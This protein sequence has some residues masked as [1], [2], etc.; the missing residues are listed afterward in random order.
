MRSEAGTDRGVQRRRS[1]APC[2]GLGKEEDTERKSIPKRE[3]LEVSPVQCSNEPFLT[4]NGI[5]KDAITGNFYRKTF[6]HSQTPKI[7]SFRFF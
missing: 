3:Q 4:Q 6:E 5:R 1:G 7:T 2:T